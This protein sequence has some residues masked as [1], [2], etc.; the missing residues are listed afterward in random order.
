MYN[1]FLDDTRHQEMHIDYLR[2]KNGFGELYLTE[3]WYNTIGIPSFKRIIEAKGLPSRISFDHD[4]GCTIHPSEKGLK[5]KQRKLDV[6]N[7][8]GMDC[9]KWL[10]NYCMDNKI[11]LTSEI[12]VHSANEEGAKNIR[13]HLDTFI[14]VYD[15]EEESDY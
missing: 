3:K 14:R 9:A 8:T 5:R 11:K 10:T 1:L 4:L 2:T 6:T 7:P 13:A 12:K 15:P